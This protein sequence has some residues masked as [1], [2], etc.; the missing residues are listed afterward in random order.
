MTAHPRPAPPAVRPSLL[1]PRLPA[2]Y[3][4]LERDLVHP[5]AKRVEARAVEWLDAFGLYPDPVERAWGLATHS[6]DF[7][8]RIVPAG[9]EEAVLLFTEWN[10]WANAVDDWQDSGSDEVGT[11]AVVEHGVRLLRT[12]EDPGVSLLPA[13]PMTRALVDLVRRTHA[14]LTPSELRRFTEG[15]RDWLL[16]AAWRAAQAETGAM[17]T[18]NDFVA[19]G[20]LANGTRFSLTWSDAA[21]GDRLPADLLRSSALTALTD[22]AGFVVSADND[23]F[24]YDKDDHLEPREVNL[25]NVLA[26]Q[27]GCS[28]AEAVPLAVALRD[29]VMVLFTSLRARLEQGADEELRRHLAALGH[30]VAGCIAWQSRAPRYASPRNRYELPL[31]EARFD[32]RYADGPSDTRTGPPDLPALASWWRQLRD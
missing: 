30:Y 22:A 4:P 11:G 25:V 16:G 18:L 10:H 24:S 7:S 1:G 28:P 26:H 32:I 27:E 5:G 20:P 2:F 29:R 31:A 3:C 9:S 23:L 15:T 21:R 17:P 6:A 12:I 8:C 19:M 13:G 14:V